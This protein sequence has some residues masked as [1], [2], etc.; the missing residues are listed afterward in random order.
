MTA[1]DRKSI[2]KMIYCSIL[3]IDVHGHRPRAKL[4]L[5]VIRIKRSII[6][7]L[8]EKSFIC[9]K[10]TVF[11]CFAWNEIRQKNGDIAQFHTETRRR[12]EGKEEEFLKQ[13]RHTFQILKILFLPFCVAFIFG[14]YDS[15]ITAIC[16]RVPCM[17]LQHAPTRI[18][19]I[20]CKS[21]CII[22]RSLNFPSLIRAHLLIQ[23]KQKNDNNLFAKW[24]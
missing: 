1:N 9:V 6:E 4:P 22:V 11:S 19:I 20:N 5:F 12:S 21:K 2:T 14:L 10:K 16:E 13:K 8:N 7:N 17:K 15:Q 23:M 24:K 3:A 18:Q